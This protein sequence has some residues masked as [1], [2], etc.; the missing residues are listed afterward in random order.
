[1]SQL[2]EK[3]KRK[4]RLVADISLN[5]RLQNCCFSK[6]ILELVRTSS[7]LSFT[8]KIER[9]SSL[10]YSFLSVFETVLLCDPD[11]S[12]PHYV[13]QDGPVLMTISPQ[14]LSNRKQ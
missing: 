4:F 10:F 6:V 2:L 14:L 1:M 3:V 8:Y 11:L 7:K 9:F 5:V 13:A 12:G